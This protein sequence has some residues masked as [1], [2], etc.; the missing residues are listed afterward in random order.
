MF[1]V[2]GVDRIH[3]AEDHGMNFL[4]AGQDGRRVFR[5]GDGVAHFDV[6]GAFDVGRH[7]AGFA[8]LQFFADVRFGIEAADFLDFDGFAGV[9]ELDV[10]ARH[11]IR[12]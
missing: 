8:H 6:L 4:E 5:V 2:G 12:R 3:A 1:V 7:V 11:A 9:Q 10:H